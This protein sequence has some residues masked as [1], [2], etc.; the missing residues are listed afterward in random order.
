M[1]T[2][3]QPGA[4]AD[5]V[6]LDPQHPALIAREGDAWLDS[7]VF[8]A[9]NGAVRSVWRGGRELVRHGRHL[10]RDAVAAR[11]AHALRGVLA[12]H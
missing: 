10:Q 6:E 1:S 5:V 12:A 7:W 4:P 8:A 3:L 2:G 11:F 9:R